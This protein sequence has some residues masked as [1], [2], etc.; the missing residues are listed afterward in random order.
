MR[1]QIDSVNSRCAGMRDQIAQ[2]A[3][4][5]AANLFGQRINRPCVSKQ[6]SKRRN[7]SGTVEPRGNARASAAG[8]STTGAVSTTVGRAFNVW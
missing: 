2:M 3:I 7:C 6:L 4:C 1:A 5:C 8:S